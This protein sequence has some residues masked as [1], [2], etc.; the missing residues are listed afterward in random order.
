MPKTQTVQKENYFLSNIT[1]Q[2]GVHKP[3]H[4]QLG[5]PGPFAKNN[6]F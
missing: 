6:S 2:I 3:D 4:E 5:V 1:L